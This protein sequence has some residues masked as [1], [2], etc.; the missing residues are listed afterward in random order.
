MNF[1]HSAELTL[2]LN[3][4]TLDLSDEKRTELGQLITQPHLD[5]DRVQALADRHRLAP[6]LYRTLQQIPQT[7]EPFLTSLRT[8]CQRLATDN[9]LKLHEYH[10]VA[11]LLTEHGIDHIAY[12]G[13]HL[14]QTYYPDSSLRISGDIDILVATEDAINAIR[15]LQ[16]NQYQL[17]ERQTLY[18]EHSG[19]GLLDDLF[20][21]SLFKPFFT[22]HF[23]IDLHWAIMF[24]NRDYASFRLPDFRAE[25]T[26][27]QEW[28]VI[29]L[30]THHGVTNLWQ[31]IYYVN[32]LYFLL[33]NQ[34]IDWPWLLKK[35]RQ[36]GLERVFLAGLHWCQQI[37]GLSLPE[38]VQAQV[39]TDAIRSLARSYETN[40]EATQSVSGSDL[41]LKQFTYFVKAQ[42]QVSKL[43]N[44]Y[45]TSLTSRVFRASTFKIG[46]RMIYISKEWGFVTIFLRAVRSIYRLVSN[47]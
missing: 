4:C 3:A 17:N 26:R 7:P 10:Q 19:Q 27:Q 20:E 36:Y 32:D 35:L 38:S 45:F 41:V 34:S 43:V 46:Q 39:A 29:L 23:D 5:L 22:N 12:K 8:T 15:L 24:F 42:T 47:R 28:Q 40:W 31:H 16:A 9:L 2:L 11:R 14:A 44:I 6:F 18:W 33:V 30:V 13:V 25:P 37:W 21:V 1:G